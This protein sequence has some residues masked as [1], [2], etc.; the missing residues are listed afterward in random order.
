MCDDVSDSNVQATDE[1]EGGNQQIRYTISRA[2]QLANNFT[3]NSTT[4]R[5][6]LSGSSGLDFEILPNRDTGVVRLVIVAWDLGSP[7]LSSNVSVLV[8]VAVGCLHFCCCIR[9]FGCQVGF[10]CLFHCLTSS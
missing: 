5:L 6:G 10:V 1:D 9:S 4:G 8:T 3:I 7:S 2:S